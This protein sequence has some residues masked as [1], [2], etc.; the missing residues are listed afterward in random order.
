MCTLPHAIHCYESVTWYTVSPLLTCI[1][2][3]HLSSSTWKYIYTY[4]YLCKDHAC[5][6]TSPSLPLISFCTAWSSV[7]LAC[8]TL[9]TVCSWPVWD[10]LIP[11][12]CFSF[13]VELGVH[14]LV[15]SAH[16]EVGWV[17]GPWLALPCPKTAV[18]LCSTCHYTEILTLE[19]STLVH[20]P[21]L[22][23]RDK[24]VVFHLHKASYFTLPSAWE[25]FCWSSS[26]CL[27]F[28][29]SASIGYENF[30]KRKLMEC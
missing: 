16:P 4:R 2:G 17:G 3:A 10:Q 27:S 12:N 11:F 19:Q 15:W 13:K 30:T 14:L 1:I 20:K 18:H 25:G 9:F 8:N 29:S 6:K 26:V 22:C 7:S 24:I 28:F 21:V 5:C 23:I